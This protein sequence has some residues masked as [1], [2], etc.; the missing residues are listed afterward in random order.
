MLPRLPAV[1]AAI[2]FALTACAKDSD[3]AAVYL[4]E[5]VIVGDIAVLPDPS[6]TS[7]TVQVTTSID[8]VCAVVYGTTPELGDGIAT[9]ADMGGG[10]HTDH[11]A[12]LTGL[13]PDTEY[14]LRVQ[15]SGS[16]SRLYRSELLTFRTPDSGP[17]ER[18]GENVAIGADVIAVSSEFSEAFAATNAVDGDPA[19]EWST[20]GDGDD[21]WITID[22]GE[23]VDVIGIGFHSREMGDGTSIIN[24]FTVTVDGDDTFGPYPAGPGLA[25]VDVAFTGR[26]LR[27]DAVDTTGGN[28]G[29]V[30]IEIYR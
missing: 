5:D 18:P 15:G 9:D 24:M 26:A 27:F 11:E 8:M 13:E 20:A 23:P 19:T 10:A 17:L 4:A 25:I 12:V 29:A 28:T 14:Y 21:A 3:E 22:L 30:E 2:V 16:D 1:V 7:A 6:G